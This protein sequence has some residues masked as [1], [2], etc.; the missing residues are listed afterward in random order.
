MKA[1]WHLHRSGG[2]KPCLRVL[3]AALAQ[4]K[5]HPNGSAGRGAVPDGAAFAQ[6]F[7]VLGI[8]GSEDELRA[9]SM[10]YGN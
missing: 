1:N 4:A 2:L 5:C 10:P 7:Y 8:A 9:S 3:L 6:L